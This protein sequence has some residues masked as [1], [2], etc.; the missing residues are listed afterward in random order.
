MI[1]IIAFFFSS[2]TVVLCS[3]VVVLRTGYQYQTN[4]FTTLSEFVILALRGLSPFRNAKMEDNN[5][6]K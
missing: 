3:V 2:G 6:L 4:N 5:I 1:T